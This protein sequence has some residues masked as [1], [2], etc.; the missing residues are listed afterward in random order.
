ML[1]TT[2]LWRAYNFFGICGEFRIFAGVVR[3][4]LLTAVCIDMWTRRIG[5]MPLWS[6]VDM[7]AV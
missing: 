2:T 5:D 4:L 1:Q 3:V 6:D 7:T